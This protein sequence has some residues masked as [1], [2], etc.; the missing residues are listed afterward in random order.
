MPRL[1]ATWSTS[2]TDEKVSNAI[3]SPPCTKNDLPVHTWKWALRVL[4]SRPAWI[5]RNP[6]YT[7]NRLAL[8]AEP[9]RPLLKEKTPPQSPREISFHTSAQLAGLQ[10]CTGWVAETVPLTHS[11]GAVCQDLAAQC[12]CITNILALLT[13]PLKPIL[14]TDA[15]FFAALSAS[16]PLPIVDRISRPAFLCLDCL[17]EGISPSLL[18]KQV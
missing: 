13:L 17:A 3:E 10:R 11:S 7:S 8:R 14:V 5:I 12:D 18:N 1:E 16:S 15:A 2:M 4:S 9:R 6:S